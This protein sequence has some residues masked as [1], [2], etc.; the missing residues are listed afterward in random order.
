MEMFLKTMLFSI[1]LLFIVACSFFKMFQY[2]TNFLLVKIF[3][4]LIVLTFD[5]ALCVANDDRI[6][7][8]LFQL[9]TFFA[10][11]NFLDGEDNAADVSHKG[12]KG[13]ESSAFKTYIHI[14]KVLNVG[15]C[16]QQA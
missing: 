12:A 10:C 1:F 6:F 16:T 11:R 8:K 2:V 5:K 9:F 14:R 4:F 13:H 3:P 15:K 7:L